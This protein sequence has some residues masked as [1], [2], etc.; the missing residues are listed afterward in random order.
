[1]S[2][3]DTDTDTAI[4]PPAAK[5]PRLHLTHEEYFQLREWTTQNHAEL[6]DA[7]NP[8]HATLACAALGFEVSFTTIRDLRAT[9]GIVRPES[10]KQLELADVID[11]LKAAEERLAKIEDCLFNDHPAGIH[12]CTASEYL[13][14]APEEISM[15][16]D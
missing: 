10:Q 16:L 15:N 14:M 12:A 1:M 4:T 13:D 5:K 7:T 8:E 11:R 9:L 3:T 6:L 2:D